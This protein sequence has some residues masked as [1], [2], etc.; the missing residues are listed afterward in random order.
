MKKLKLY[1]KGS[2]NFIAPFYLF[3]LIVLFSGNN[4]A[5]DEIVKVDTDLV[6]VPITVLDR[7]G[8]YITDLK[9]GNFQ[10]FD[11]GVEGKIDFFESVNEPITVLLLLDRSGSMTEHL[12]ELTA[13]ANAFVGQ[14]RPNDQ[15]MAATFA[16]DVD[17]LMKFT[18]VNNMEKGIKIRRYSNDAYTRIY[19]GVDYALKK[20]KKIRGR[21]AIVVFSD[22]S[23]D[24]I[25]ASFKDNMRDAEEGEAMIYTVQFNTFPNVVPPYV[26][27]KSFY[28]DINTANA[29]MKVLPVITGGRFYQIE[30]VS[31]LE[32]TFKKVA[33]ELGQQY[34]I[35][36]YPKDTGK[37][38]ERRQIKVKVNIPNTAVRSRDSYIVGANK[39]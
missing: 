13:A 3:V 11:N 1:S 38:G 5:Q 8:R 25:L 2:F 16:N 12:L 33:E 32:E 9:K 35:G 30:D 10:I 18:K 28:E 7:N 23:G 4:Y 27:K 37:K 24:G 39:N 20:M 21:K 26:S 6:T 19:D 31:N 29:Y 36:Y 14:L 15:V 34:R 22:G 17:V